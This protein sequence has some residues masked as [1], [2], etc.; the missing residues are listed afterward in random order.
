ML[1]CPNWIIHR[2]DNYLGFPLILFSCLDNLVGLQI[3]K[4]YFNETLP[5]IR[6]LWEEEEKSLVGGGYSMKLVIYLSKSGKIYQNNN[7]SRP[8]SHSNKMR[9]EEKMAWQSNMEE[10]DGII[11]VSSNGGAK[12]RNLWNCGRTGIN[13]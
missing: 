5:I 1:T 6:E 7:S 13:K 12:G 10:L 9:Y 4:I 3:Y 11:V 2:T 8:L